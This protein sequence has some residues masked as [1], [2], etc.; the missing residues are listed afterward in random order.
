MQA[1]LMRSNLNRNNIDAGIIQR[2][3]V[4]VSQNGVEK[5]QHEQNLGGKGGESHSEQKA[6]AAA[7]KEISGNGAIKFSV[8]GPICAGCTEWFETTMYKI[9]QGEGARLFVEVRYDAFHGEIEVIGPGTTWGLVSEA[10][11]YAEEQRKAKEVREKEMALKREK[12]KEELKQRELKKKA[13][14]PQSTKKAELE[15]QRNERLKKRSEDD[16]WS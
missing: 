1:S 3:K 7:Q 16:F 6:W 2:I 10:G 14:Q 9:A 8:D 13:T 5:G 15:A 4:V 12:E 11:Y